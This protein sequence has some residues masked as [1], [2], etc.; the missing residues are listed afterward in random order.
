M[1]TYLN[2]ITN[3]FYAGS[4]DIHNKKYKYKLQTPNEIFSL[5]SDYFK[6]FFPSTFVRIYIN[7]DKIFN[8]HKILEI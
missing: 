1:R 7:K 8:L 5:V 6:I 3:L 2:K 4:W